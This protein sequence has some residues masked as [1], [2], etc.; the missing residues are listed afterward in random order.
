PPYATNDTATT[1]SN[2][3]VSKSPNQTSATTLAQFLSSHQVTITTNILSVTMADNEAVSLETNAVVLTITNQ[4]LLPQTNVTVATPEGLQYDY[5]LYTE[6]TP[7]PDF[8]PVSSGESLV[9]LVDGA[10]HGLTAT[11]VQTGFTTRRGFT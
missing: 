4:A 7:P 2:V 3:S 9:L 11:N 1:S 5:Y 8:T 10:R 6:F